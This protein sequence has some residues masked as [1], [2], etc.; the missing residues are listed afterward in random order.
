LVY[1]AQTQD[2]VLEAKAQYCAERMGLNY[3][4]RFTGYGDLADVLD[5]VAET[6]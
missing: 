3:E 4:Y 6:P 2:P 1:Q 5:A